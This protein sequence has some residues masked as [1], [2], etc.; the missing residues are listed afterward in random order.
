MN[1]K[2]MDDLSYKVDQLCSLLSLMNMQKE[3]DE[4]VNHS[5]IA[6]ALDLSVEAESIL[7]KEQEENK[8]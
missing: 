5:L 2:K 3:I 6:L 8:K 1:A 7:V 4:C